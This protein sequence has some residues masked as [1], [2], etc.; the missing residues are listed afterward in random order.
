MERMAEL[1]VKEEE[2]NRLWTNCQRCQGSLLE[3]V[4]CSNRDCTVFYRRAKARKD[5]SLVQENL[6]RLT[7]DLDW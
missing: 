7:L 6:S 1:R 4:I 5:I 2:Y 3:P